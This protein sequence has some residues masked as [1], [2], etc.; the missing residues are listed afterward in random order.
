M[1][2]ARI[3]APAP[4]SNQ[5]WQHRHG[6]RPSSDWMHVFWSPKSE[7]EAAMSFDQPTPENIINSSRKYGELVRNISEIS[8]VIR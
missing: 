8:P 3:A 7:M 4:H 5:A 2:L 1:F 6:F